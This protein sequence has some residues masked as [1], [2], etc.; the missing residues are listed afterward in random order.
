VHQAVESTYPIL[1]S[2]LHNK[3]FECR[4]DETNKGSRK[5]EGRGELAGTD[6]NHYCSGFLH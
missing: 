6:D 1:L 5:T 3:E 4:V 2:D